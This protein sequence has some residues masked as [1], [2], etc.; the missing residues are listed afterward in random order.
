MAMDEADGEQDLVERTGAIEPPIER[1]LERH[2]EDRRN[3]ERQRERQQERDAGAVH[4]QRRHVAA[5]HGESAM[6]EVNEIHQPKRDRK[7]A[8]QHEQEHSVGHAVEQDRQHWGSSPEATM[9]LSFPRKR[10][11]TLVPHAV[12]SGCQLSRA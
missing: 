6:G 4:H 5:D 9:S 1:A 8:R 7:P 12:K 3:K 11:S 10:E 2:A